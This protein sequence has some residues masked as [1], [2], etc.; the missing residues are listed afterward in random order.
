ML[1]RRVVYTG[2]FDPALCDGVSA[3]M[4]DLLRFLSNRGHAVGIVSLMHDNSSTQSFLKHGMNGDVSDFVALGKTSCTFLLKDVPVYYEVTPQTR[5]DVLLAHPTVLKR[6]LAK[7]AEYQDSQFLTVDADLTCLLAH[8]IVG[9]SP[10]HLVH[11]PAYTIA[12]L[13][14][15]S[16]YQ[17]LLRHHA[18]FS[19]SQFGQRE[20][21]ALLNVDSY[22][23]PPCIDLSRFRLARSD[24][25]RQGIGYYAAGPHKGDNIVARLIDD[26]VAMRKLEE[27]AG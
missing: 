13:S 2:P 18:V 5:N 8:S 24:V 26:G 14:R 3:S 15:M 1:R 22:V 20:L 12:V 17:H 23:W 10:L 25:R 19:V 4:F 9:T 21:K 7:I 16:A 6:Y 27:L 11:S